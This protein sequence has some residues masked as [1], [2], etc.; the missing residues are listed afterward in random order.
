M[1]IFGNLTLGELIDA[2]KGTIE[3]ERP[4]KCV[5]FDFM[6]YCPTTL[7]SYRGYYDHC[8]IDHGPYDFPGRPVA[9][10]VDY[11]E[12]MIGKDVQSW[13]SGSYT[14]HRDRPI[15]VSTS[16]ECFGTGIVGVKD[17]GYMVVIETAYLET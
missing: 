5:H 7:G 10:F 13:K 2:L 17:L 4:D 6:G 8:D 1:T 11:L 3:M 9:E 15:W 14:V 12:G 16:G